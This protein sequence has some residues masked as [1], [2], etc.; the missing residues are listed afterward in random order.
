MGPND[1]PDRRMVDLCHVLEVVGSAMGFRALLGPR[2]VVPDRDRN[3][4]G[5]QFFDLAHPLFDL[6]ELT[7]QPLVRSDKWVIHDAQRAIRRNR[8][9]D[10][11]NRCQEH[12]AELQSGPDLVW[13]LLLEAKETTLRATS[14]PR[15]TETIPTNSP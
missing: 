6:F 11:G 14:I 15:V 3:V 9:G 7:D 13:R 12:T 5:G 4:P 10:P 1:V 2:I 8:L